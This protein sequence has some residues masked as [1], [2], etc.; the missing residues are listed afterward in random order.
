MSALAKMRAVEVLP[1]PRGPEKRKLCGTR[2][3]R[4]AFFKVVVMVS[5]PT[6]SSNVCGLNFLAKIK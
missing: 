1:T 2:S 5:C 4:M 6:I 3:W